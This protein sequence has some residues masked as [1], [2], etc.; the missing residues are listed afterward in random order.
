MPA[1]E[2]EE[3]SATE[4]AEEALATD[5]LAQGQGI[6]S[7]IGMSPV[8]GAETGTPSAVAPGDTTDHRRAP[9]AT[10]A[11]RACNLEVGVEVAEEAVEAEVE[12]EVDGGDNRHG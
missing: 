1:I 4:E 8:A 10:V 12:V 5:R 11:P 2:A 7:G 9:A 3:D 6:V